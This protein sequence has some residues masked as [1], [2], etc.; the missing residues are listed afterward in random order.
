MERI[1][2]PGRNVILDLPKE[3]VE[4]C[5]EYD[6]EKRISSDFEERLVKHYSHSRYWD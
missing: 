4:E 1:D 5:P 2:W 3:A 6:P